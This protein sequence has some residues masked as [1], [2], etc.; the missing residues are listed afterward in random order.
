LPFSPGGAWHH[1]CSLCMPL[2]IL[3]FIRHI[4]TFIGPIREAF[5]V[6]GLGAKSIE[7]QSTG[8]R[9]TDN[10]PKPIGPRWC[11]APGMKN[12]GTAGVAQSG[13]LAPFHRDVYQRGDSGDWFWYKKM[14][15]GL[16]EMMYLLKGR[17]R[18]ISLSS[19]PHTKDTQST[20]QPRGPQKQSLRL[21]H[22][23]LLCRQFPLIPHR[24]QF[25]SPPPSRVV[26]KCGKGNVPLPPPCHPHDR[27]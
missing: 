19:S 21:P 10:P 24:G 4:T 2:Y 8:T 13:C 1:L 17:I 23:P 26:I 9:F 18:L 20:S 5:P 15:A 11:L 14:I 16:S 25:L 22:E 27:A 12:A 6:I 7:V 3:D